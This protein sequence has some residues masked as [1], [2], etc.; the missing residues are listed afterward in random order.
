GGDGAKA[1]L[2]ARPATCPGAMTRAVFYPTAI[3]DEPLF[4][5]H[6]IKFIRSKLSKSPLRGDVD[7]LEARARTWTGPCRGPQSQA[8]C[9][10][11]GVDVHDDLAIV[12]PG[13]CALELSKGTSHPCLQ[14]R[15]G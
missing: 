14:P 12:D 5:H 8:P 13:H 4:C 1:L 2:S 9:P 7:L 10:A 15:P 3:R 11:L 6:V